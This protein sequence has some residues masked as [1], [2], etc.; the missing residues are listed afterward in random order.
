MGSKGEEGGTAH[1][2]LPAACMKVKSATFI[3]S[4][5]NPSQYPRHSLPEIAFVGRSNVGKSSLINS[6]VE[7]KGLAKTSS[8]PGKTRLINFF[9]VNNLLCF[10]DLPGYGY[11][12]APKEVIA[13]WQSM[14]ETYLLKRENLKGIVLI[15][16][17]RHAPTPD[18]QTMK[19]WLDYHRIKTLIV[20]TK[21]DKL[22]KNQR[23]SRLREIEK[24]L[25]IR[26]GE[27]LISFS[28]LTGEGKKEI[29]QALINLAQGDTAMLSQN[30]EK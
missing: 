25:P 4:A 5:T 14:I 30:D 27:S 19:E 28:A 7:K 6:L 16:D 20:A 15:L 8:T 26:P 11:A 21:A 10:V 24:L 3:V 23:I 1:C 2:P 12:K 18:D 29:W 13:G 9:N 17:I 22:S